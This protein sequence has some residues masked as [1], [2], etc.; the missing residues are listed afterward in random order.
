MLAVESLDLA[1][2]CIGDRPKDGRDKGQEILQRIAER[3]RNDN[4]ERGPDQVLLELKILV[5]GQ[6]DFELRFCSTAQ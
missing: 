6:E 5:G 3:N 2:L 1:R 4:V